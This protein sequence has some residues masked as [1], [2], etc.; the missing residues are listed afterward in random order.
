MTNHLLDVDLPP[1]TDLIEELCVAPVGA[2]IALLG[3]SGS[4]K[5]HYIS[6]LVRERAL[7]FKGDIKQTLIYHS[8]RESTYDEFLEEDDVDIRVG[9]S[10]EELLRS[11]EAN[12]TEYEDFMLIFDD[13]MSL[14]ATSSRMQA[15]V[16]KL[17]SHA[18]IRVLFSIQ[19]GGGPSMAL[20]YNNCHWL[21]IQPCVFEKS[22]ASLNLMLFRKRGEF[23]STALSQLCR[24]RQPLIHSLHGQMPSHLR[25]LSHILP[26]Q[27]NYDIRKLVGSWDGEGANP[28][29]NIG[30]RVWK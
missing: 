27:R 16:T 4:G 9:E 15:L 1:G 11:V 5:S 12:P 10:P 6:C 13:Y 20:I 25:T 17:S 3:Q 22:I 21:C 30:P 26:S 24:V 8:Q 18:R 2:R 23:L 29:K 7:A 28:L 14:V 19:G